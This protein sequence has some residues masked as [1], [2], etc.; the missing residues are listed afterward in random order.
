MSPDWLLL[1]LPLAAVSGWLMATYDRRSRY[2]SG[3]SLSE[4]YFKRLN[5]LLS[6]QPDKALQVF[7]QAV[8]VD[9]ESVEIHISLGNLFRHRGEV[10]RATQIHHSLAAHSG[11][12]KN[13]R[14]LALFELAQDY[15]KAGL[16]DRA[17]S[18]FQ[19]LRQAPDYA[20]QAGRFLLQ[21]Y[22][23]EKEWSSAIAV[24]ESLKQTPGQDLS[25][26]LAHYCCELAEKAMLN[27]Q[28]QQAEKHLKAAFRH[29]PH[30]VRA[31]IQSGLIESLQGNHAGA[32]AIW[33]DLEHWAPEALG[34]VVD[35]LANS[36]RITEDKTAFQRFLRAAIQHNADP[37]ILTAL[38]ELTTREQGAAA[39]QALLLE[40]VQRYPSLEGLHQLLQHQSRLQSSDPQPIDFRL[41]AD[42]LSAVGMEREYRC[43]KCGFNSNTRHWQCPSCKGW[44]EVQKALPSAPAAA[45][46]ASAALAAPA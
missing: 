30:C 7:M 20:E 44:G 12:D 21:I 16:F 22:D 25:V 41:L 9:Q 40:Q 39:A 38:V 43:R 45:P 2:R 42:V 34:E 5:C 4:A 10:Q 3:H 18:L 14:L 17:E 46:P 32:I 15:F 19:E 33:R 23:Q 8:G 35:H 11:L 37:R 13:L 29:D 36:Y 1:L 31:V 28:N 24:A 27:G 6:E 26:Q